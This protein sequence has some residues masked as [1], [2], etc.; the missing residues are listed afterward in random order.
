VAPSRFVP[1][2]VTSVPPEVEPDLGD[3]FDTDGREK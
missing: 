2:I 1:V 3:S